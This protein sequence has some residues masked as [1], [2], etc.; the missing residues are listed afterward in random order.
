MLNQAERELLNFTGLRPVVRICNTA[1]VF[2]RVNRHSWILHLWRQ[3][4]S[5]TDFNTINKRVWLARFQIWDMMP[6]WMA[7][8]YRQLGETWC[9]RLPRLSRPK[10]ERTTDPGNWGNKTV[11]NVSNYS[12]ILPINHKPEDPNLPVYTWQLTHLI[13]PLFRTARHIADG[14]PTTILAFSESSR[15]GQWYNTKDY[16]WLWTDLP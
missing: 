7:S 16:E 15:G 1:L 10:R 4:L 14:G 5:K 9:L 3:S 2:W 11:R 6:C 8:S 13:K 12:R